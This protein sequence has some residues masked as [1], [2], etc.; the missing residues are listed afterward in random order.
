[1]YQPRSVG[2]PQSGLSIVMRPRVSAAMKFVKVGV[3]SGPASQARDSEKRKDAGGLAP[4]G[5]TFP[6]KQRAD[7]D[8]TSEN[9]EGH[10]AVKPNAQLEVLA[11]GEGESV[12]NGVHD[13]PSGSCRTSVLQRDCASVD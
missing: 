10:T 13:A 9:P 2:K 4:S 6:L 12:D 11:V 3:S 1:M 7:L 5:N 8:S